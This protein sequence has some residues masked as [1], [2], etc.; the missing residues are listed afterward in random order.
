MCTAISQDNYFG[1][2]LDYEH[3][4]GEQ[5]II[6][7]KNYHLWDGGRFAII[8]MGIVSKDFPLYFDATNEKG[9]SMAGLNFPKYCVY[10]KEMPDK[11]NIPSYE[12]IPYILSRCETVEDAKK[13]ILNLN[14]TDKSFSPEL[15]PSPLH[16]IVADKYSSIT[17]E[18]TKDGLFV[19]HNPIGVLT[20]SPAFPMH[21]TNLAN[22]MSVTAK[23]PE[24]RFSDKVGLE[25]YSRGMGG[26]GLPG[27]LSSMSRFVR[28]AFVKL[29]SV[30]GETEE[31]KVNQ[32]FHVLGSVYQQK[33]CARVGDKYEITNY[34]SCCNTDKGIYYYNTYSNSRVYG[35]DMHNED[36]SG[37]ELIIYDT[38][39]NEKIHIQ[40]RKK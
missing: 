23:E 9:L 26:L 27:D 3:G 5:I 11:N 6:A 18:Q 28:A 2:N 16:W 14:I 34:S 40:N 29:N 10:N 39:K 21:M 22:Y 31:E 30:Y 25:P 36:L 33:G 19:Y 7:P 20:N 1:R 13:V 24:N 37:A 8:G 35:V 4:F 15:R 17:L 32:F 38:I 12:L